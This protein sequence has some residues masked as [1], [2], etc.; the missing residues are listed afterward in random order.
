MNRKEL[1]KRMRKELRAFARRQSEERRALEQRQSN[2][3]R[4]L[5][6]RQSYERRIR[7]IERELENLEKIDIEDVSELDFIPEPKPF[8]IEKKIIPPRETE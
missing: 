5:A 6:R 2:E 1:A 3:R 4:A 8:E 7:Q